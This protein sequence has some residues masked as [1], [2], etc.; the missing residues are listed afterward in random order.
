M[1]P[2]EQLK[3][4][5]DMLQKAADAKSRAR[6]E[7]DR[8]AVFG[9]I[10]KYISAAMKPFNEALQEM[11][12]LVASHERM[13]ADRHTMEMPTPEVNVDLSSLRVPAPNVTVKPIVDISTIKMPK[14]MDVKGWLSLQG[15]D[16]SFLTNPLPVQLRDSQGNPIKLFDNLTQIVSGGGGW[17]GGGNHV[18]VDNLND[19]SITSSGSSSISLVNAD[20]TYYNSDNPLPVSFSASGTSQVQQVSGAMDSVNIMQIGGNAVTQGPGEGAAALRVVHASDAIASTSIVSSITLPV[21]QLSGAINSVSIVSNIAALDIRQVSGAI[22]SVSIV[23]NIAALDVKQLSGSIDSVFVT[24][25]SGTT[26]VV[27][28]T[29]AD[30]VDDGSAPIQMGGIARTANPTAVAGG[31]VVKASMD[32]LGRQIVRPVQ[33][34]DLLATAYAS[35]TNGTETTLATAT[36]GG[37]LDLV[38]VMGT[39]SSDAAVTVDLRGGSGG[40]I[41]ASIRIPANGTAGVS[42]PVP[43][44]Q[45]ATGNAWTADLP[46]ITGTTVNISALFTREV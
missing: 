30:A 7:A 15:Y 45:D 34:R 46:D 32:D 25:S 29:V 36:T 20:G 10:G 16:R 43:I 21:I 5:K 37:Y 1:T 17:G 31:D 27:G 35:L 39:N 12:R 6:M 38:Y 18:V 19:I 24:G 4:M 22:D 3:Q 40:N 41:M 8:N 14:E 11:K 13:A 44:P 42:L 23:S 26:M 33:V 9:Q 2:Q 28:T